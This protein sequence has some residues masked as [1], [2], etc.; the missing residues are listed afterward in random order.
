MVRATTTAAG[1]SIAANPGCR[2]L[3]ANLAG[4]PPAFVLTAECD[5]LRDQGEAYAAAS[6]AGGRAGQVKR[7]DGMFHPFFSLGGIIDGATDGDCRRG[8]RAQDAR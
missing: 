4:L 2:P 5:P 1:R 3:Y 8:G 6:A 7:Y